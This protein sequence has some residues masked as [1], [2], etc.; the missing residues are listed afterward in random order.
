ME[1]V[2]NLPR[3]TGHR[4][5]NDRNIVFTGGT[6]LAGPDVLGLGFASNKQSAC[7]RPRPPSDMSEPCE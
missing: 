1:F 6:V 4:L 7:I 2:D 3:P 5:L